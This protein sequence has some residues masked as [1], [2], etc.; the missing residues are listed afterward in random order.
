[1][2]LPE[3]ISVVSALAAIFSA[4]R[5]WSSAR[6]S[7]KS[8]ALALQQEQARKPNLDVYLVEG[9]RLAPKG[10]NRRSYRFHVRIT[11][12]AQAANTLIEMLLEIYYARGTTEGLRIQIPAGQTD[13]RSQPGIALPRL[14]QPKESVVGWA[15]FDIPGDFL[16]GARADT[17]RIVFLDAMN[18]RYE[19]RPIIIN[20][21][22]V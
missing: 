12:Q 2:H 17:Y 16:A 20:E 9:E 21:R 8:Y 1:M 6:S 7:A 18:T 3:I 10:D 11:N 22:E 4:V 19:I 14:L 15:A 13:N 5:A